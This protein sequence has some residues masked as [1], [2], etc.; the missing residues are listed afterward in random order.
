MIASDSLALNA[1][2]SRDAN[3]GTWWFETVIVGTESDPALFAKIFL[4]DCREWLQPTLN[5]SSLFSYACREHSTV[6]SVLVSTGQ[7]AI[8]GFLKMRGTD[9]VRLGT[10]R[11]RLQ[12]DSIIGDINWIPIDVGRG[13]RYTADELIQTVT[14]SSRQLCPLSVFYNRPVQLAPGC[15]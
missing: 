13:K 6:L 4:N 7:V 10:L 12:H 2:G 15:A 8:E 3:V 11:R 14:S 9:E 5:K 1:S